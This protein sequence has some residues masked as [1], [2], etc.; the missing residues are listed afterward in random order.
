MSPFL[1]RFVVVTA[2]VFGAAAVGGVAEAADPGDGIVG[3]WMTANGQAKI[4]FAKEG[5]N[6]VGRVVWLKQQEL[7]GRPVLDDKNPDAKLRSRPMMGQA[8]VWGLH[9]DGKNEY[10]S[11]HCYDPESGKTY[12][13]KAT[14]ENANHLALRGYVG[15]PAFGR[16]E[17]WVK[18]Q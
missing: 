10:D 14:L 17:T 2:V 6:Y 5:G 11:G 15:I 16:S 1:S 18:T 3:N 8:I 4:H 7:S 12:Q 9:F 13:G